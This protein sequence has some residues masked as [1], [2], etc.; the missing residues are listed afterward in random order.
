MRTA[1]CDILIVPGYTN[2]GPA[3]WQT[4]W[5]E[6]LSTARRIE[7]ASWDKPDF[8]DWQA[9]I[10]AAV[11]GLVRPGVIVARIRWASSPWSTPRRI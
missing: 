9:R 3:H 8:D 4:R 7:Q 10:V 6:K 2:S 1:D 11:Q 5:Q